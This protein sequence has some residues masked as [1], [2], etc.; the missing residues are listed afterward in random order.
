LGAEKHGNFAKNRANSTFAHDLLAL[1]Y[2]RI[3]NV[4]TRKPAQ[5]KNSSRTI[6]RFRTFLKL[7]LLE[8]HFQQHLLARCW[9]SRSRG[10]RQHTRKILQLLGQQEN[11]AP[12][13]GESLP[14]VGAGESAPAAGAAGAAGL[15][16][17]REKFPSD[18]QKLPQTDAPA[19]L[20]HL[21]EVQEPQHSRQERRITSRTAWPVEHQSKRGGVHT[22]PRNWPIYGTPNRSHRTQNG[23]FLSAGLHLILFLDHQRKGF[24]ISCRMQPHASARFADSWNTK[25]EAARTRNARL[26]PASG[27]SGW[28]GRDSATDSEYESPRPLGL[29]VASRRLSG[30]GTHRLGFS[31]FSGSGGCR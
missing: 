24:L 8:S 29:P 14:A 12:A 28:P 4:D 18:H 16:S 30:P 23:G 20:R 1:L 6:R 25:Q 9:G 2:T 21:L 31:G 26:G 15:S 27:G 11:S 7:T 3:S 10:T 13:A 22:P 5:W 19:A 17:T